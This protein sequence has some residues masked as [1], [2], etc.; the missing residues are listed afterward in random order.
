MMQA[1]SGFLKLESG[2]IHRFK[3]NPRADILRELLEDKTIKEKCIVWCV[4]HEDFQTV[5][6]VCDKLKLGYAEVTGVVKDK[7]AELQRFDKDP[8]CRVMIASQSAGGTGCE[9]I[10]ASVAIY[11]SKGHS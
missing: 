8:E 11:Y 6:N 5:K 4:Y 1:L 2:E 3:Q 10:E 7:E 9:M